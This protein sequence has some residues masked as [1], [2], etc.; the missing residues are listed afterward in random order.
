M[1]A[2]C[3]SAEWIVILQN[4]DVPLAPE[5]DHLPRHR[6][7]VGFLEAALD[8]LDAAVETE[9]TC[10]V[11]PHWTHMQVR[12]LAEEVADL[13]TRVARESPVLGPLGDAEVLGEDTEE[14]A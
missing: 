14:D 5:F 12:V 8:C 1:C 9:A 11:L 10:G 7:L 2:V 13:L 4:V 6:Q 3:G